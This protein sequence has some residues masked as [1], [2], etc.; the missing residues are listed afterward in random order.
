MDWIGA[1]I[2]N[3]WY[4]YNHT[5]IGSKKAVAEVNLQ[6]VSTRIALWTF[7]SLWNDCS[8]MFFL[9][10]YSAVMSFIY[11]LVDYSWF[12]SKPGQLVLEICINSSVGAV[13]QPT[14]PK[15][16]L[17]AFGNFC[18]N[19]CQANLIVQR[20]SVGTLWNH[21]EDFPCGLLD[22]RCPSIGI[23]DF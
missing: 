13:V 9:L 17:K 14:K 2:E 6:I 15:N 12:K 20:K 5:K 11:V 7:L 16:P 19:S 1:R 18:S 23:Q 3:S 10:P 21:M 4:R 22:V 8:I